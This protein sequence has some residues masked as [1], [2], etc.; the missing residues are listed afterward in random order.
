MTNK[1]VDITIKKLDVTQLMKAR[2]TFTQKEC[3]TS[4]V[5]GA[6]RKE[7]IELVDAILDAAYANK[8]TVIAPDMTI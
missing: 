4:N 7:L 2:Q 8:N 3:S 5:S 6:Y 1:V